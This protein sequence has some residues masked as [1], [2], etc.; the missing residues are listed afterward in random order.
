L[1]GIIRLLD[2]GRASNAI[3]PH[4]D[5]EENRIVIGEGSAKRDAIS[6]EHSVEGCAYRLNLIVVSKNSLPGITVVRGR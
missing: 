1:V 6:G 3:A 5:F 2:V 4:K